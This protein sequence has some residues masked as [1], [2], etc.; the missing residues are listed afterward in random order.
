MS[1]VKTHVH[2]IYAKLGAANR[3]QALALARDRGLL[4]H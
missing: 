2:H 3:T 4:S 1:T